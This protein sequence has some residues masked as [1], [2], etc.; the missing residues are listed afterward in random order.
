MSTSLVEHLLVP[1]ANDEDARATARAL[2]AY[3]FDRVTAVHVIEKGG[4]APD[5]MP[6][7]QAEQRAE[8]SFEAFREVLPEA[9]TELTYHQNVVTAIL[10]TA[11]DVDASAIVFR[12]RGGSRIVQFLSGDTARKLVTEAERPV[13]ALPEGTNE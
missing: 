12:P 6:L 2:E 10:D 9:S 8:E 3:D 13:I 11:E 4:G 5:K 7:E 1:I